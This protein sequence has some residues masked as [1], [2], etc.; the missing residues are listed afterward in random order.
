MRYN[1]GSEVYSQTLCQELAN[2]NHQVVVFTRQEDPFLADYTMHCETDV[3]NENIILY[4][5]NTPLEK[6][7]YRYCNTCIDDSFEKMI[8]KEQPDIVHIGHLNHLSLSLIEHISFS[9][10][11]FY[12]LHDY[13]LIC[14]RGQFIQRLPENL[15]DVW[16]LCPKQNSIECAKRCYSGYF[17]GLPH[18]EA[19]DIQYWSEWVNHR[20]LY[21]KRLIDRVD[22]FLTP[23]LYLG[24]KYKTYFPDI[25][26]K[27]IYLDY[28]FDRDRFINRQRT[29]QD[30]F[31]FGYIGTHIPAKGIHQLIQAFA[32]TTGNARL[33][34]WGKARGQ[35][36]TALKSI[37]STFSPSIQSRIEWLPEY[38]NESIVKEVFNHIDTIV[39]PSV[40]EEN[41]PLV[42]HEA[43]EAHVPV[44]TANKGGMS[45]YI[46]HEI[47]GLL[48]KHRSV[49]SL[50]QQ[51]QRFIDKPELALQLGKKG[52]LQSPDGHIPDIETHVHEIEKLYRQFIDKKN[53]SYY[54]ECE[55][56]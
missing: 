7:R 5:I 29:N 46:S 17:S 33:R 24:E 39:V 6:H 42:I 28:G 37:V 22:C 4:L 9:I 50:A 2:N 18:H 27:L 1:A 32:C 35:N 26:G 19:E 8:Q 21:I 53:G 36:T 3:H 34:I 23:S 31:T 12:T 47:N 10:P 11:I 20:Q 30:P 55:N 49:E 43:L 45:E 15:S 52:Y 13:W 40:W 41:S 38:N 25:K 56:S 14:P 48:F 54:D 51:M 44:I 16:G